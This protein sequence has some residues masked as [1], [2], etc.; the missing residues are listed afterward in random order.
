MDTALNRLLALRNIL[1]LTGP[2]IDTSKDNG[3]P[4]ALLASMRLSERS[5]SSRYDL[6]KW[7][8]NDRELLVE[9][10]TQAVLC[11]Y[12]EIS[13]VDLQVISE[14][15][16]L[17]MRRTLSFFLEHFKLCVS[18]IAIQDSCREIIFLIL[19]IMLKS[20]RAMECRTWVKENMAELITFKFEGIGSFVHKVVNP[21][22]YS[23]YH[24]EQYYPSIELLTL[25]VEVGG[26]NVDAEND[27]GQTP[28]HVISEHIRYEKS[29]GNVVNDDVQKVCEILIDNGAHMDT[30]D[31]RGN[32]ASQEVSKT[33]PR[34]AFNKSLQCLAAN[35]I[36][37]HQLAYKDKPAKIVKFIELHDPTVR[38]KQIDNPL[39]TQ[40]PNIKN[41][42][43]LDICE[44]EEDYMA[45]I[46]IESSIQ[47]REVKEEMQNIIA[48]VLRQHKLWNK[49]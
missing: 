19:V 45:D 34:W 47:H 38:T 11:T 6:S 43:E 23:V 15:Q 1:M 36:L 44:V 29:Q 41:I 24:A 30:K 12:S 4:E 27:K 9:C 35:A 49:Y 20:N 7:S 31:K 5:V 37:K 18:F 2:N 13:Q 22:F 17:I 39:K 3:S 48:D 46:D 8:R 21:Y 26:M 14:H 25:L 33:F 40:P 16:I 42:V 32:E 28:L 10:A